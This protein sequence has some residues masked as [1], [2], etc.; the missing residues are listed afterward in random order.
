MSLFEYNYQITDKSADDV[1]EPTEYKVMHFGSGTATFG[2]DSS[3]ATITYMVEYSAVERFIDT[4]LGKTVL[5]GETGLTRSALT[6]DFDSANGSLPEE[7]PYF[8]NFYAA[9]AEVTPVGTSEQTDFGPTWNKARVAVV[10]RP[11]PYVV[12]TDAAVS[13][14]DIPELGR[15]V[16]TTTEASTEF[17]TSANY[18]RFVSVPPDA[19]PKLLDS[20]Q[21]QL[22]SLIKYSVTWH[23]IPTAAGG[24][25]PDLTNPPNIDAI[26]ACYGR[27]NDETTD[28]FL[29]YGPGCVLLLSAAWKLVL[30]QTALQSN[31]YWDITYTFGIRD[32]GD[33]DVEDGYRRGWN[34][35][36]DATSTADNKWRLVSTDGTV[37]GGLIYQYTDLTQLFTL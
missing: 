22:V 13:A 31:Y 1:W 23:Q 14:L 5:G 11:P 16:S 30:P 17:L 33:S 18:F 7:H 19:N 8:Y 29:G 21:G 12:A 10:F 32:F 35:V 26:R 9:S 27:L 34:Y 20:T 25:G 36:Y 2:K 3:Q 6:T 15:F 24:V 28:T 37:D 4:V